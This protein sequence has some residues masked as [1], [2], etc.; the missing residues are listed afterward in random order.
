MP[1]TKTLQGLEAA[2]TAVGVEL[3][4]VAYQEGDD[5]KF[6]VREESLAQR[7]ERIARAAL[8]AAALD[9]KVEE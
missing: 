3:V 2:K 7:S 4:R 8:E 9:I 5:M 1:E 6:D